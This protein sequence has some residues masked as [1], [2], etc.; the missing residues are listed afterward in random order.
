MHYILKLKNISDLKRYWQSYGYDQTKIVHIIHII[1]ERIEPHVQAI[2]HREHILGL[3]EKKQ[4]E[5]QNTQIKAQELNHR[6]HSAH[7]LS[8]TVEIPLYIND[9]I[10]LVKWKIAKYLS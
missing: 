4:I 9:H 3:K 8:K 6:R 2:R 1:V 5:D 10:L 7:N